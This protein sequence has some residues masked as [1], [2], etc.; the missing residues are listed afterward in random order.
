MILFSDM[1][2]RASSVSHRQIP[3]F[4]FLNVYHF[5]RLQSGD[6]SYIHNIYIWYCVMFLFLNVYRF[7]CLQPQMKDESNIQ[8][9]YDTLISFI[10]VTTKVTISGK[11]TDTWR[12]H[13]WSAMT[14][15]H[16]STKCYTN[17]I[18]KFLFSMCTRVILY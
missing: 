12:A 7:L 15:N 2:P 10:S 13:T 16:F 3:H 1:P 4:C 8:D 18:A 11:V 5:L 17:T 14:S 9:I 6:E